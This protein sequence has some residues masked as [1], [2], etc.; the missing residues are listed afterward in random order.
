MFDLKITDI[1]S[2]FCIGILSLSL[3]TYFYFIINKFFVTSKFDQEG[4][5]KWTKEI[6]TNSYDKNGYMTIV[7]TICFFLGVLAGD[8][9]GR[10]T[11]SDEN[12][13]S[14]LL[15]ELKYFS[16]MKS[17]DSARI[18][19]LVKSENWELT[20]LGKSVLL[21]EKIVERGNRFAGTT[22][23]QDTTKLFAKKWHGLQ[24][25]LKSNPEIRISFSRFLQQIYYAGKNWCYSTDHEPLHE[26]KSIQN[27]ID[28]SRSTVLLMSLSIQILAAIVGINLLYIAVLVLLKEKKPSYIEIRSFGRPYYLLQVNF[29]IFFFAL[30]LI[31]K[32][33]Y[34]INLDSY[35]KRAYGY[36]V[37]DVDRNGNAENINSDKVISQ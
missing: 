37:S 5:I 13:K 2:T 6:L 17:Q 30:L 36:Y 15:K 11:D 12:P 20:G 3:I 4:F 9:T 31:A 16:R 19:A 29:F 22:F 28:L 10:M 35:N 25:K 1:L 7:L 24:V 34:E 26:L 18:E 21:S 14:F 32:E 33:C 23:L 8:L 27:R